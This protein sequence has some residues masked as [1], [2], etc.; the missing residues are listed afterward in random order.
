MRLFIIKVE[1]RLE[2]SAVFR[3]KVSMLWVRI[4]KKSLL[5]EGNGIEKLTEMRK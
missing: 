5:T 1:G 2:M 4:K 3:A